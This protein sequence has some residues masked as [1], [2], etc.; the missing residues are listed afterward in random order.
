MSIFTNASNRAKD[1]AASYV[2]AVLA[3]VG[4]RDPI[5]I[6]EELPVA[7]TELAGSMSE[8]QLRAS[9]APGKWSAAE[10]L[11]HLADSEL[12]WAYRLRTVLAEAD[13]VV[14]GFDQDRWAEK[15]G[16]RDRAPEVSLKEITFLRRMNLRLVRSLTEDDLERSGRHGERGRES[17]RHMIRLYAGHDL[18]HRRQFARIRAAVGGLE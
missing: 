15:L 18:V 4:D 3:L 10:L 12:V 9:E 7:L 16:Y 14:T 17:V 6:L 11:A 8:V 1:E 5:R 13:P 2:E